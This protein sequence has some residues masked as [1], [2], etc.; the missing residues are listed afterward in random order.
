[1]PSRDPLR[2]GSGLRPDE[3]VEQLDRGAASDR[4]DPVA[5]RPPLDADLVAGLAEDPAD[6]DGSVREVV[7]RVGVH[8]VAVSY[9]VDESAAVGVNEPSEQPAGSLLDDFLL[10][11]SQRDS[12]FV[13]E[14]RSML[15]EET[16]KLFGVGTDI[17]ASAIR[18]RLNQRPAARQ[19]VL[20]RVLTQRDDAW[21]AIVQSDA[22]TEHPAPMSGEATVAEVEPEQVGIRGRKSVEVMRSRPHREHGGRSAS[23]TGME[24]FALLQSRTV[25]R[26]I[27]V[28]R[29]ISHEF[30]PDSASPCTAA[31]SWCERMFPACRATRTEGV[32]G[33][34]GY[35]AGGTRT[36]NALSSSGF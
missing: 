11:G 30:K 19:E 15:R 3:L 26:G 1:M 10:P 7:P 8:P 9:R 2:A 35:T 13:L 18:S 16:R 24:R 36:H 33:R 4:D 21:I 17:R 31:T 27:P 23:S 6:V 28:R 14:A 5:H 20:Y 29:E 25:L 34:P 22:E 32:D 12:A